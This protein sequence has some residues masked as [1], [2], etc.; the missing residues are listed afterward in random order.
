MSEL[1]QAVLDSEE[2]SDLRS[3]ISELRQQEKKYLLR[4]DI[5][6]VYTEYCSKSQKPEDYYTSSELGKLIYY[7]QEIIQEDSNFC[8][9]IRSK[10]AS[11]EVYWLTSD[12]SI[13]PMTVQ[14]LLDLR[15]RLVNKYHPND[16]DLLELDFGP[17]YDYTPIIRDPK[18]IG[19][20]YNFS[21]AIYPAKYFKTP[22]NCWTAY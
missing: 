11:Q 18:N 22:N 9:I 21:T 19:K 5:L 8:F 7:T 3:F 15:D 13:E 16:G 4:N 12:L 1:L 10:I 14:D 6:N 17:F 20:G 2:R